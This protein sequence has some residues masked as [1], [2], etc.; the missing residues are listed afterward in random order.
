MKVISIV[1]GDGEVQAVP[2]LLRRVAQWRTPDR[3][4][5]VAPPIRVRKDRFL[6]RDAEFQRY[7]QLAAAKCG[8]DGWILILLD[9][10][11]A[12]PA[13]MSSQVLGRAN[14]CV[15]HRRVSIVLATWHEF[16]L[17]YRRFSSGTRSQ[18]GS[19]S[20]NFGRSSRNCRSMLS[21]VIPI[22]RRSICFR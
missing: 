13:E 12:C 3:V 22:F 15:P 6:N 19:P 9:A 4:V 21:T 18:G 20:R 10:D 11:D 16:E 7:L 5:E 2:V 1:E 14:A 8:D 17:D